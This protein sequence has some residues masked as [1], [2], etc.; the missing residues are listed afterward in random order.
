MGMLSE[1]VLT[2]FRVSFDSAC[3]S[4]SPDALER[5]GG[6]LAHSFHYAFGDTYFINSEGNYEKKTTPRLTGIAMIIVSVATLPLAMVGLV[7]L[8]LS[9]SYQTSLARLLLA[10]TKLRNFTHQ[11]ANPLRASRSVYAIIQHAFYWLPAAQ[12]SARIANF[13]HTFVLRAFVDTLRRRPSLM[14]QALLAVPPSFLFNLAPYCLD[15][16]FALAVARTIAEHSDRLSK[17]IS[18]ILNSI[19]HRQNTP[20]YEA[21]LQDSLCCIA[22]EYGELSIIREMHDLNQDQLRVLQSLNG[23]PAIQSQAFLPPSRRP[24]SFL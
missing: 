17:F 11:N 20:Q 18:G 24:L 6:V 10:S 16:H 13:N 22:N 14:Q 3:P 7:F 4:F 19:G 23:C 1:P 5:I 21:F 12:V 8:Q 15:S 2:S 9:S